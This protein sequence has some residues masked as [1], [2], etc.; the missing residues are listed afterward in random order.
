ML[1]CLFET[2]FLF[3]G[4]DLFFLFLV[5][6]PLRT[7]FAAVKVVFPF[8][9][10]CSY[11]LIFPLSLSLTHWFFSSMLLSLHVC[12]VLVFLSITDF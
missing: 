12:A 8:S 2:F 4:E 11:F 7:A 9:F 5:N 6:F 10:V 1:G 3:L